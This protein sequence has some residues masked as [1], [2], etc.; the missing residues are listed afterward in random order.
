M[1]DHERSL[2]RDWGYVLLGG[3]RWRLRRTLLQSEQLPMDHFGRGI[4]ITNLCQ[5]AAQAARRWYQ[6]NRGQSEHPQERQRRL[7]IPPAPQQD[8]RNGHD[9]T[10]REGVSDEARKRRQKG[11]R[12]QGI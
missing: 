8:G 6:P 5:R 10:D 12:P 2:E 11:Q 7:Q 9:G 1:L 4:S 3:T